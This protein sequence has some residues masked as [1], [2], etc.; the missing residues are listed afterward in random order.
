MPAQSVPSLKQI[1]A[2]SDERSFE[3]GRRYYDDGAVFDTRR[4]GNT[5]KARCEGS[6][7]GPYRVEVR[8]GGAGGAGGAIASASCSCPVGDGGRCKHAVAL[9]LAWRYDPEQFAETQPLEVALAGRSKEE[10]IALIQQMIREQPDFESILTTPLPVP[11]RATGPVS[12]DAYRKQAAGVFKRGGNEWGAEAE[13]AAGLAGIVAIGDRFAE[14]GEPANALS[15]YEGAAGE[16]MRRQRRYEYEDEP[17]DLLTV[18][19]DCA[20]RAA[21]LLAKLTDPAARE[22]LLRFLFDVFRYDVELGGIDVLGDADEAFVR[23]TT[24]A[25]RRTIAGWVRDGIKG[26]RDWA[27]EAYGDLLL[28][29]EADTLDDESYIRVCREAGRRGDVIDRLLALNR[30]GEAEAELRQAGESYELTNLADRFVAAGRGAVA[31]ALV[32]ERSTAKPAR[33]DHEHGRRVVGLLEWL[34]GRA[35]ARKD[36]AGAAALALQIFRLRPS[37]EGYHEIKERAIKAGDWASTRPTLLDQLRKDKSYGRHLLPRIHLDE[38]E[39]DE[40]IEA[41][42]PAKRGGGD[43]DGWGGAMELE[44]AKAAEKLR[45]RF[46]LACYRKQAESLI[47]TGGR[48]NYKSACGYLKKVRTIYRDEGEPEQ[49]GRYL[50]QLREQ[51][52]RLSALKDEMAKAKL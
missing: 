44:V 28:D 24:P 3:R 20:E 34:K 52:H 19:G 43:F 47:R 40:A 49:W 8:L 1:Q 4:E 22:R 48:P 35:V 13:I 18:V 11:G 16:V 38:G 32:L 14:A 2:W 41:V 10:L 42:T 33:G 29:L 27:R 7:G 39:I 30:V 6:Q 36:A 9:L 25:E 45:P 26:Q 23:D 31:E 51:H 15:V 21:A 5:L 50:A 12:P 17:G 37:I 46:A